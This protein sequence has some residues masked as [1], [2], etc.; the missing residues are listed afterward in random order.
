MSDYISQTVTVSSC[1]SDI[2]NQ[3]RI[4]TPCITGMAAGGGGGGWGGRGGALPHEPHVIALN[5]DH[6]MCCRTNGPRGSAGLR[7]CADR[8]RTCPDR[9]L[10]STGSGDGVPQHSAV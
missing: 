1:Q 3:C 2:S 6:A 5:A 4:K 7:A 8:G 10:A 9:G